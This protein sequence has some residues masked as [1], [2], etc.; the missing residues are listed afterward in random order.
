MMTVD[1]FHDARRELGERW[2][3]DG[4]LT[5]SE[6]GIALGFRGDAARINDNVYNMVRRGITGPVERLIDAFREGYVPPEFREVEDD[7]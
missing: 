1:E 5:L 4:P 2:G 3:L 7:E 6:M